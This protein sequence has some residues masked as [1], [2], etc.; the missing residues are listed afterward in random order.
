MGSWCVSWTSNPGASSR[1]A[2]AQEMLGWV[3][4][5]QGGYWGEA[6]LVFDAPGR[7]RGNRAGIE[8]GPA[9][10]EEDEEGSSVLYG[11]DRA[12]YDSCSGWWVSPLTAA[13]CRR[14]LEHMQAREGGEGGGRDLFI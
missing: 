11:N 1:A 6:E 5:Q 13:L 14:A 8:R 9:M 4:Q 3:T 7:G 10:D 12:C 2:P